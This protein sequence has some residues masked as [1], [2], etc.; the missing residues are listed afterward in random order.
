MEVPDKQ[1]FEF[2]YF[3]YLHW[4]IIQNDK[5]NSNNFYYNYSDNEDKIDIINSIKC[6]KNDI[7]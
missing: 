2:R 7:L 6:Y 4:N 3:D 5:N 1:R